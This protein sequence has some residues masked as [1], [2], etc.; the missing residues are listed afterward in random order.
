MTATLEHAQ[1]LA[2]AAHKVVESH[3][4]GRERFP[5]HET[6]ISLRIDESWDYTLPEKYADTERRDPWLI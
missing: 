2:D 5:R 3:R 4:T 1:V 6:G